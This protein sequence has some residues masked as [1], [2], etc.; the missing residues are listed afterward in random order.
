MDADRSLPN[1]HAAIDELEEMLVS[2]NFGVAPCAAAKSNPAL[3]P[4]PLI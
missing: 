1:G 4:L 2:E 3:R